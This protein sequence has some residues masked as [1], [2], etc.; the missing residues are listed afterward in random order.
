M[1]FLLYGVAI[2]SLFYVLVVVR[3]VAFF[4]CY[5]RNI[6][7]LLFLFLVWE[8]LLVLTGCALDKI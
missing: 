4:I 7:L 1:N 6:G 2:N 8:K 5:Q 3:G